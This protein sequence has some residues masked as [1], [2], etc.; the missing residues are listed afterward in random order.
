MRKVFADANYW[1]ALINE[2]DELH[3]RARDVSA[4]LGEIRFVT[5][6]LVLVE[7]LNHLGKYGSS[8]RTA[9]AITVEEVRNDINT[10]TVP[11]TSLQFDQALERYRRRADKGWSLTDCASFLVME[12]ENITEA[13]SHD[14]HFVQAGFRA[15]LRDNSD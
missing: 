8:I 3:K 15:L 13:L 5:S 12:E 10:I 14:E 4:S 9:A 2:A 1:I 6:E 11:L 7:V